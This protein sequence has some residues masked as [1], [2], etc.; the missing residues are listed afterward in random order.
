MLA[1]ENRKLKEGTK[2]ADSLHEAMRA[3]YVKPLPQIGANGQAVFKAGEKAAL[4]VV[5]PGGS[6]TVYGAEVQKAE[7]RPLTEEEIRK[8]LNKTGGGEFAFRELTVDTDEGIFLPVAEINRLRR[9]A[10][11]EAEKQMLASYR[12]KTGPENEKTAQPAAG[13]KEAFLRPS[14]FEVIVRTMQQ[15]KAAAGSGYTERIFAEYPLLLEEGPDRVF[16]AIRE[17]GKIPGA[18]LPMRIR[19]KDGIGTEDLRSLKERGAEHF[20]ARDLEGLALLARAGLSDAACADASIYTMQEEARGFVRSFAAEDTVPYESNRHEMAERGLKGSTLT[21][22]GYLPLMVT[23]QCP[24]AEKNGCGKASEK[25]RNGCA[26]LRDR[27]DTDFTLKR[28]CAFCYNILYN[29][30]PLSLLREAEHIKR[31]GPVRYRLV[32]S[33]E[34]GKKCEAVLRCASEAFYGEGMTGEFPGK[35]T[36]GHYA[37][38]VE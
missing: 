14:G 33:L 30:V 31:S 29:S 38:G 5:C 25:T 15:L 13:N 1:V 34:D 10:F 6:C 27:K 17:A 20:L 21:V 32:F 11:A 37:R 28:E 16:S 7:R 36:K 23:E 12:R 22:Y 4:T 3:A 19:S 9:D 26:R 18:A 8:Q 24:Y 2:E 35:Y